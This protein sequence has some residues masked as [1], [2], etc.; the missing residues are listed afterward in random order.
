MARGVRKS[1]LEKLQDE[2]SS[3]MESIHQYE[4]SIVTLKN[5]ATDLQKQIEMEEFK[6]ITSWLSE[7]QMTLEDLKN[8][9]QSDADLKSITQIETEKQSA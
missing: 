8:L 3:V 7:R 4:E 6:N 2:L 1:Q 9:I 5:K